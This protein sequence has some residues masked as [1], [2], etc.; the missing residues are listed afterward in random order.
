MANDSTYEEYKYL[1]GSPVNSLGA[2]TNP[3][4]KKATNWDS[5]KKYKERRYSSGK[6]YGTNKLARDA[7]NNYTALS[8]DLNNFMGDLGNALIGRKSFDKSLAGSGLGDYLF[9][10]APGTY[11]KTP[12]SNIKIT[13]GGGNAGRRD[14]GLGGAGEDTYTP[15]AYDIRADYLRS[16][17]LENDARLQAMYAQLASNILGLTPQLQDIYSKASEG[18]QASNQAATN[19]VNAGFNTARQQ[20][21]NM[22]KALG[23]EDAAANILARGEDMAGNQTA[24][25]S[26]LAGILSANLN[27]NTGLQSAGMQNLLNAAM[28]SGGEGTR[29]RMANENRVNQDLIANLVAQQEADMAAGQAAAK[30]ASDEAIAQMRWGNTPTMSAA[31]YMN[32]YNEFLSK[33]GGDKTAAA[34]MMQGFL[35]ANGAW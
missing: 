7:M 18:Y 3:A 8:R 14:D 22:F 24:N 15:D 12:K 10:A 13:G 32:Q 4:K 11:K 27:R 28:A 17:G 2:L 33:V 16:Q 30:Q 35:R 20:Q 21:A 19:A 5:S 25:T 9:G 29:S 1:V 31:D 34:A 6:A 23:I 26:N